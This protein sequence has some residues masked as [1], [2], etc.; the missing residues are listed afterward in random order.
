MFGC[1]QRTRSARSRRTSNEP[2]QVAG[3]S[4]PA[5]DCTIGMLPSQG[6]SPMIRLP[7]NA[8]KNVLA[9]QSNSGRRIELQRKVA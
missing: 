2:V 1:N 5:G 3:K 8:G 6:I 9:Y 4:L 7:M